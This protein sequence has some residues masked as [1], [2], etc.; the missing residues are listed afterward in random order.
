MLRNQNQGN[1]DPYAKTKFTST[2]SLNPKSVLILTPKP[3][4]VWSPT[5]TMSVSIQWNQVIIDTH[6]K[7]KRMPIATQKPSECRSL[8]RSRVN[9]DVN[10]KIKP[11]R[12]RRNQNQGNSD[13]Y[14]KTKFTSTTSLK[15]SPCWS[16]H[17]NQVIFDPHTKDQVSSDPRTKAKSTSIPIW[18]PRVFR[19]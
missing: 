12:M 7:T 13:P 2:T 10:Y 17:W 14:T 18:N 15:P 16:L 19:S 9:L 3:S 6:T 5:W 8:H 4:Q 11:I 1:S